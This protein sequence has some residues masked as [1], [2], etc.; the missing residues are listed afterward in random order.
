MASSTFFQDNTDATKKVA[1]E[2]GSI[3][4]ATTRTLTVQNVDGT[5]A[6][7]ADIATATEALTAKNAVR[8]ATTA[9]GTL[10]TAYADGQTVDGVTLVTGDRILLKDQTTGSENG[11]YTVNASGSPTRATDFNATADLTHGALIPVRQGTANADTLWLLATDG[12]ITVGTTSLSF[13]KVSASA[14]S[15]SSYATTI[16]NGSNTSFTVTHNLGSKDVLVQVRRATDDL[17]TLT[18]IDYDT[19]NTVIVG[20]SYAPASNEFRV[21]VHKL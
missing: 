19:T 5:I 9:N 10:S 8:V 18:H 2:T 13:I 7:S 3:S 17:Q 16:G 15:G 12:A 1:L 6:L 14:S 20:F 11:I 4:T 21:I